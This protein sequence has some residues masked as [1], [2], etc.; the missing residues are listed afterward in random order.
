M[1]YEEEDTC[2]MRRRIH[3]H[4][5]DPDLQKLIQEL[6]RLRE[7]LIH[8]I[9]TAKRQELEVCTTLSVRRG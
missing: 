7:P 4:T 5:C 3:V 1:A 8:A 2:N 9:G 6:L